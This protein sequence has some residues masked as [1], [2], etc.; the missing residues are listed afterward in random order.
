M[1]ARLILLALLA[2]TAFAAP[3]DASQTLTAL[4]GADCPQA[5]GLP[6]Y[7]YKYEQNFNSPQST[8]IMDRFGV[9]HNVAALVTVGGAY[10]TVF[11]ITVDDPQ[12]CDGNQKWAVSPQV[13]CLDL[14]FSPFLGNKN[15]TGSDGSLRCIFCDVGF[16][17]GTADIRNAVLKFDFWCDGC[18]YSTGRWASA[19]VQATINPYGRKP[20]EPDPK[21]SNW[22]TWNAPLEMTADVDAVANGTW[23][24]VERTLSY[25]ADASAWYHLDYNTQ[26]S[27]YGYDALERIL[28]YMNGDLIVGR[29]W[30]RAEGY[31]SPLPTN[32]KIR[33]DNFSLTFR[34]ACGTPGSC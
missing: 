17:N 19:W 16:P 25:D 4:T 34:H 1:T 12:D 9:Y 20:G 11:E 2:L 27:G 7:C 24:H 29:Y 10:D 31:D 30:K 13:G 18:R 8:N 23:I 28:H 3:A 14:I 15:G 21:Y 5:P 26:L 22:M 33:I 32:T 6:Q